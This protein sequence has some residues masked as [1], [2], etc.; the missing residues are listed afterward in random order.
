M[1]LSDELHR[2]IVPNYFTGHAHPQLVAPNGA[3]LPSHVVDALT[4]HTAYAQAGA[5]S[6]AVKV[7]G[8]IVKLSG[9]ASIVRN[10]VTIVANVGD[11]V[12]QND[13]VQTGSGSTLGLAL[14][15]GTT[16]N[17]SE[18]SRFQL[19]ELTYDANSTSNSLLM[20]LVQGA[21]SFVAGQVARSGDMKVATPTA[22]LGIRGTAVNLSVSST[23]GTVSVSVID[24]RDGQVHA[25]QVFGN[26]GTLIGTVTS[27]GASLTLTPTATFEVIAQQTDK[28]AAQV[29][30]EFN[31]FQQVLSTYDAAKQIMPNLPQHTDNTNQPS[32]NDSSPK[33]TS[34]FAGSPP[35]DPPGT[36]YHP[37]AA[38]TTTQTA[39]TTPTTTVNV[40]QATTTADSAAPPPLVAAPSIVVKTTSLPFIVTPQTVA[41]IS[42]GPGDHTGPVMSANGDLVYDPDGVIYYY[43]HTTSTT[44]TI[45]SPAGG[46][47]YGLP[48]ISLDGR[49]IVYQGSNGSGTYVF[50]YGT[51]PSDTTHYHVQTQLG[52]GS[53]P[54]VSGDGST[55]VAEQGAGNIVIYD[56]QGNLKGTIAARTV[57]SAGA[58][59]K[60]ALSADGHI[61]AFWN[62]D[63]SGPGGSGH[64]YTYNLAT[65][66][67]TQIASTASGA[68]QI[69]PTVSADGHLIAYQST[70]SSGHSEIY[71]YDLDTGTVVF[72]TA[73]ASGSSYYP[74]LSPDGHF[75]AFTSDAQLTQSDQNNFADIYI[76]D[77]T[78]PASPVYK[79]VSEGSTS[80]SYNGVAISAGGQYVAFGDSSSIYFADPTSGRAAVIVETSKSP[81]IL[82][83]S[84]Q[85]T[86]TGDYS[87]VEIGVTDQFGQPTSNF[88]ASFDASGHINWTFSEAKSDFAVLSY[89]QDATQEFIITLSA[90]DG[91]L[92]IPVFVTVHDGV[93]P[94]ISA[95]DFAPM[96][97]PVSLSEGQQNTA[98]TITAADL[99]KGVVDIDGPSLSITALS[100][101]SGGGNLSQIDS[102]TWTYTPVAGF[103]GQIAFSYTTTD[104]IK[105]ASST[106]SLNIALP[107]A[108]AAI[109]P[110]SG[111]VGDFITSSTHLTVSGTNGSLTSGEKIQLSSDNGVTWTDVVQDTAT[112]W[113]FTDPL[114]HAVSFTYQ[115][116]VV[117]SS[118]TAINATSQAVVIDTTPPVLSIANASGFTNQISLTLTGTLDLADVGTTVTVFDD[119]QSI[120]TATVQAD[121]SWTKVVSLHAGANSLSSQAIDVAGN[122]GTSN[123]IVAT[124]D[125]TAPSEALA[126]TAIGLDTGTPG[127]FV[128]SDTTLTVSGTNGVL[129][130]DEKIQVSS[131]G[132]ATW[133]DVTQSTATSWSYVDLTSHGASFTYQVR[134]VD[135]AGNIGTTASQAITIDT[136]APAEALAITAISSDS[137]AP[138][139]FITS[140]TTLTVSGTNG[141]L[142][143]DE[144]IQVSS[145]GGTTWADVTQATSTTWTYVDPATHATSFTYQTRIVDLAGNVGTTASHAVTIDTSAPTEPLVINA[146]SS[147]T[148]TAGDFVTS[149]MTLTVSG[150]NGALAAGEKIQ[151][152]SDG[153]TTWADVTQSTSTSW[154]YLDP[155]THGS[156]FVYQARIVDLAANIGTTASQAITIDTAAPAGAPAITAISTDTGTPGDFVTSDTT[157]TVSGTNGALSA[158]EKIQLSSDGGA[159]WVDVTQSTSTTWSYLDPTTHGSSFTYLARIIDLAGNIGTTSSQAITVDTAAPGEA[160]AIASISPDTGTAGDFVTSATTLTVAGTNGA[161]A[162]GEKI[163]VSSDGG[164]SWA[165]ATQSTSTTWSY[166]DPAA[167]AASF[168]YQTRIVDLAGNVGTTASHAV[169]IDATAPAEVLAISAI[170]TD[171][172]TA[173]DFITN[174]TSLTVTG[175]NGVLAT[176]EKIQISSDGGATWVDATQSTSTS[177]SY[178]DSASHLGSFTYQT[179][180]VDLAG[181]VGTTASQLV[182]IDTTAPTISISNAGGPT[183]QVNQTITGF[184]DVA[185]AGATVTIY[186]GSTAVTTAIVQGNGSWSAPVAL[187]TGANSLTA[188]VSDLAGNSITSN[189]VVYTLSTTGPVLTEHLTSDTGSSAIDQNTSNPALTGT[190][191]ASTVVHFTVDGTAIGTTV[192]ADASGNWSFTPSSLADGSHTIVASQTDTFGNTGS[193][194]QTFTLDTTAPAETLAITAIS[195]DTGTPGD[196]ITSDTT[197]TV[198]GTNGALAA[199]EK[200]QVSS[201]GGTSWVDVTQSTSTTWSCTDLATHNASFNYL[202]RII[203]L[204]G[205]SGTTAS[206]AITIDTTAPTETLAITAI[207][208]DTGTPGDFIT[209][210]TTLTVSGTNGALAVGEKI[211]VSSDGGSTWADVTQS[212]STT[213]T[214]TDLATHGVSFTYQARIIDTAGNVGTTASHAVNIDTS[215][216]AEALAITAINSDTG[217]AGDFVT[218]DTTLTVSGTNGALAAGEKIQVSSDGGSSWVD[219]TQ[220]T[221]TTWTYTDLATHSASFAYQ[222]RII[223]LAGNIGTTTSQAIT[224]D[225]T[226]PAEALAIAAISSDTGAG[227]DFIT[228]DTTLT[229]SGTN[230]ALAAGEKIQV[231]SDGGSS[232][233]DVTQSTSTT[234]T[235]T[236]LATHSASFAYQARIIDLAGN[237][238]TTTSQAITIDNTPP[239]EALA[240]AAISS[241][242]GTPGDFVTSDTSLTVSGTSGALAAG[243]KIQVSSDGGTTWA[244]VTQS[245]STT[246]TYTDLVTHSSS[247]AYQARIIDL[248]GNVGTTSNHAVTIDTA[249][250]AEALAIAAISS[251]TGTPSDFVTSDTTLTVFGTN[252]SLAA[253]EKI[254]VSSDGGTTWLD[255]TQ[256]TSTTW[257]YTDLVT[258]S[259]NFIYQARIIDLAG[260]FGTAASQAITIDTA[261]PAEVLAITAISQDT[262]TPGDFV[263]NDTILTVSGTSGTLASGE[264]IQVSS[265]GGSSWADATQSTP[266]TWS[267]DDPVTHASSFTY[268]A[269][270]VDL[271]GNIGTTTAH[272]VTIDTSAPSETLAIGSVAGA[273]MSTI[274]TVSGS[275][276]VLQA[277]DQVQVSTDGITWTSVLNLTATHWIYYDTSAHTSNFTYSARVLDYSG[278]VGATVNQPVVVAGNGATATVSGAA[279]IVAEVTGSGG[280]LQ[281]GASG[282]TGALNAISIA[283]GPVVI[284]GSGT[285]TTISGDAINLYATAAPSSNPANITVNPTGSVTGAANGVSVRQDGYGSITITASAPITGLSGRGIYAQEGATGVGSILINGAGSVTGVGA[286]YSGITAAILNTSNNNDVTVNEI[287]NITGGY[288]GIRVITYGNGNEIITTGTSATIKGLTR[289]GIEAQS[290]GTGNISI[291]TGATGTITSASAAI[292][293][294][295]Q[296]SAIP[297]VG[298]VITSSMSVTS[299]GTINSGTA[300][301]G[302]S[303]RPAGVLAG[304]KGGVNNTVNANVYGDVT[305]D[306]YANINAAFGDG[307]RGYNFGSGNVTINDHAGTI[308]AKDEYGISAVSYGSGK[309]AVVTSA[310]TNIVS[311]SHGITAINQATAI[312]SSAA[313]SVSVTS[314]GTITSGKHLSAGG[315][316]PQGISAGYYGSNGTSN[317]NISGTVTL[318]NSANVTALAGW[319][320]LAYNWGNGSVTLTDRTGTTVWGAQ[321]GI[322]AA[323]NVSGASATPS[324]VTLNVEANAVITAGALYGLVGVQATNTSGGSIFVT[325][326]SGDQI[327]SGG[328][329]INANAA[330][331][332]AAAGTQVSVTAAGTIKSGYDF[333]SNAN[334]PSGIAAGFST[335]NGQLNPAI[336]G[337]VVVNTSAAITAAAGWGLNLYNFGTGNVSG[338]VQSGSVIKAPVVGLNAFAQGGGSVTLINSGS[339]TSLGTGINT[340]TGNGSSSVNGTLSV[341]NTST[342]NIV[343]SGLV[344]NQVVQINN[345]NSTHTATFANSGTVTASLFAK[346]TNSY[347]LAMYST[348]GTVSASNNSGG[349]LTGNVQL[350]GTA[351]L[352]NTTGATWY[353]NGY[354]TIG[355]T[356]GT[357]T[358]AG[359]MN[360]LG[361]AVLASGGSLAL[362]NS[363]NINVAPNASA[364]IS[365]N[366]SGNGTITIGDRSELEFT[367]TV[368]G[369]TVSFASGHGLLTIDLPSSSSFT[370]TIDHLAVGDVIALANAGISNATLSS[371]T[372]SVTGSSQSYSYNVTNVQSGAMLDILAADK[373]MLI[374]SSSVQYSD[375]LQHLLSSPAFS[376]ILD[377]DTIVGPGSGFV[378]NATD[379]S[380]ANTYLV[381]VNQSSSINVT[382]AGVGVGVTTTGA[383]IGI[384]NAGTVTSGGTGISA[385]SG[386]GNTDV[387]DFGAV[388]GAKY[389]IAALATTGKVNILLGGGASLTSTSS[390]GLYAQTSSGDIGITTLFDTINSGSAGILAQEQGIAGA[391]GSITI[392]NESAI[393]SGTAAIGSGDATIG[394]A[395]GSAG[396]RAGILNNGGTSFT[397]SSTTGN[398]YVED[399]ANI[400]ATTGS[401]IFAFNYGAGNTTVSLGSGAQIQATAAGTTAS[402]FTQYGIYA[403]NY[404]AGS[405]TVTTGWGS[406]I[407][408]GGTGINIGNQATAIAQGSGSTVTLIAEGVINSGANNNNSGSA[409]SAIQA[410][411]NPSNA[412]VYNPNVY[413]DVFVGVYGDGT[414]ANGVVTAAAGYGISAYNYGIGSVTVTLGANVSVQALTAA[415]GASSGGIAPYGI[416]AVNLG[417]GNIIVTTGSGDNIQSGS[418]GINAVN[419]ATSIAVG[420]GAVVAVTTG[421]TIHSRTTLNNSGNQ[422]AGISAGFLGGLNSTAN[423]NV[424]GAVII[425][426]AA[427]I[428]ADAGIGINAY[429]YGNGNITVN[430]ASGANIS[431]V[432][433][434]I[435]AHS[436]GAGTGDI[437]VNVY[438]NTT[439]ASATTYGILALSTSNGS[440]SVITSAGDVINAAGAGINAVSEAST[441]STSTS[442]VVTAAGAINSGTALTGFGGQPAG[443]LAGYVGQTTN[444][445]STNPANYSVHGDVVVGNFA[446]IIAAAGNGIQAYTYGTGDVYVTNFGASITALG[447]VSPPNG[448]GLGILAQSYGPGS[449]YVST[450]ASTLINSGGSGIAA[451]NKAT[452]ADP[453]NPTIIVPETSVVSVIANGTINSGTIPTANAAGD[454]AAGILAGYNPNNLSTANSQVFG[455]V[456][457]DD[458]A[459]IVAPTGTDGIRGVNYGTGDIS[460][461][462]E[463]DADIMAGRYGVAALGYNGGDVSVSNAGSIIGGAA[464]LEAIT[465]GAGIATIDNNGFISG[466]VAAYNA[467]VTNEAGADWQ[468]SGASIFTGTSTFSNAGTIESTGTSSIQ[469]LA[470]L[471]NTGTIAVETGS[472][473]IGASVTGGG[474]AI[475]HNATLALSAASDMLVSF[476][477]GPATPGKLVLSDAAHF[478]G[479]VTG[480]TYGDTIDLVGIAPAN[481]SVTNSGGLI[482]NFGTGAF[483]LVG[484]Y[485]PTGFSVTS[486]GQGGTN[487][488]WN[489]QAPVIV[490]TQFSTVHNNTDG[491]TTITGLLV[492][493]SDSNAGSETF[494]IAAT[495]AGA[496][497]G[498]SV[499]VSTSSGS[500]STVNGILASGV[501]YLPG[502]TP[503]ATDMVSLTVTD[504]FGATQTENFIFNQA[505][506]GPNIA[507]QGTAGNDVIFAT[508]SSDVLIGGTGQD[509]FLFAPASA[510]PITHTVTD[511]TI[512]IDKLD[513]RQF[514]GLSASSVP[515]GVQVG[516]DTLVTLDANDSILLKNVVATNLHATDFIFHA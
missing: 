384:V 233:V 481:V 385:S 51:D 324:T 287:G 319:G 64:L 177:W 362:A 181:N 275:N 68:G 63:S 137:G 325:T 119:G 113:S 144:K 91:T 22:T 359:I 360:M 311:G 37:P 93:Q 96:A 208:S 203:D 437:A 147:D 364:Q 305:I 486:D 35:V 327:T 23:D 59:W 476:D 21:A 260:N 370:S 280:T 214:Y 259:A 410:G 322:Q 230:G 310:G 157:L 297:K 219:V 401:G 212:T 265:D 29:A 235:Y 110:D 86:V 171:S 142:A 379:A 188:K 472:L 108:I 101:Q 131:N 156:S 276:S 84:G 462:V 399:R 32:P 454:P 373:L 61:I 282:L 190:G 479:S 19:N 122:T 285:V 349:V 261:P 88:D 281:I 31:A 386:S 380:A 172:G 298:G 198:S 11:A 340:G 266:T 225:T 296:D 426:N 200:I 493:D 480:F 187:T 391:T 284:N 473:T 432:A 53:A 447:G 202:A 268:L 398:V 495:T 169:T 151:V 7:I 104:S 154:S 274:I 10:G 308:N 13:V 178:V 397:G 55:I 240:I 146:I 62:S 375:G 394:P 425:N 469:G 184:V 291:T 38:T 17:L 365:G 474:A 338:T 221:S 279:P 464:G 374:S 26:N 258:H 2:V 358:N 41:V 135:L 316:Q 482:V 28:T 248:A 331:S 24:Q 387:S 299:N 47:T 80:G 69:A 404:G 12:N 367:G 251:D 162:A 503:P 163:Q 400:T 123:T 263:T 345:S 160:L 376:Y 48:T 109:T 209:N 179:R 206:Q 452:T 143:A 459:T 231:S 439:L 90:H 421:G 191:L 249:A 288:D 217:T 514:S 130:S 419:E 478:T 99:L 97:R 337:D 36:E 467:T 501:T 383:N 407:Q 510:S 496:S 411:Y 241:D 424:S 102:Q 389:A 456:F 148:G 182:T 105:S 346:T 396:I 300:L 253:G 73:N 44:T 343:G 323:S 508:N 334:G 317:T 357:L 234:W 307:I 444:P 257:T 40:T 52:S 363:G 504:G 173:G 42:S 414:S 435:D 238:G 66:E 378:V 505:G 485:D 213:W 412:G 45:A 413:G 199:G 165:D 158:G 58:V 201:D 506:T 442:V 372:I 499:S 211:Q 132:G 9:S 100:L 502:A 402:G 461:T 1:I 344:F 18:S 92:T 161:L 450:M 427:S 395:N 245:T 333:F 368:A 457:I 354:N 416:G 369:Q 155:T 272:A 302:A 428:T 117:D 350:G 351:S 290:A 194:S 352:T 371:G 490:T 355:S 3:Q 8:H 166:A 330:P 409:P 54:A 94:T 138:G 89:G 475:I 134:I 192:L 70:N 392:F 237:I 289:Y 497:S 418:T 197:L 463:S 246:W 513:V 83:T 6:A 186:D 438:A 75:I 336:H 71:L 443:I 33:S 445:G 150:T 189:A 498:S 477:T 228:S 441:T 149:D 417:A 303:N 512:G 353:L 229:V 170:S 85:I 136:A 381:V 193:V 82:T 174:D 329:G 270:I 34:K 488:A 448:S 273:T 120:G 304:Y 126:I 507:L 491:S 247:F 72:H 315:S 159:A 271:A 196:F 431:A 446:T 210:D 185:D 16:F 57:N 483:A 98:Y 111:V 511:F 390:Y 176:G 494:S 107:L 222:A 451:L 76:V 264:K 403:F 127:D 341:T 314:A 283:N 286:A 430:V 342:G 50:V 301:T 318:D 56:L 408:S 145:D 67:L 465:T 128:T 326:G 356:A 306:N 250:P 205:N 95:A 436:E 124:L 140:D 180:I 4:G 114:T 5:P 361:F 460:I 204:A 223:D 321:Y 328:T 106:A 255:A 243:E 256:S 175:S 309:I 489:H 81:A 49:Y 43:D 313:S 500:L 339:I 218:S 87:G 78:N 224:I 39:S 216:P 133:N 458:H 65:G 139:D 449:V 453:A 236:D 254:Q 168:T 153:G 232:W 215:A 335:S 455:S 405:S 415:T 167:H 509:Q 60:P 141:A 74:V 423:L 20:T 252:G 269:R 293:A 121:G 294:Y 25:V 320:L 348:N 244:D 125:T 366:V 207:N 466:V 440:I 515:T 79:L 406:K 429:N 27:N 164:A 46:W 492:T 422:P 14:D 239:T 516:N 118:D 471:T 112:D 220:S 262:G 115:V 393:T 278:N 470:G 226:A 195:T 295:N 382:G 116:R 312:D 15:D 377:H 30:Q 332:S 484:N 420:V 347:A 487:V 242:T 183:N 433:Q 103:S 129:A 227:G 388:S 267:Y 292:N 434:A 77:V 152:S 468:F 277:G